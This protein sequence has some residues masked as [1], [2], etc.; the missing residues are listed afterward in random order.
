[1]KSKVFRIFIFPM[2]WNMKTE[3]K[4]KAQGKREICIKGPLKIR[5]QASDVPGGAGVFGDDSIGSGDDGAVDGSEQEQ[6]DI[7]STIVT[8]K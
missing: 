7:P 2:N 5:K 4:L 3:M 1:M 8:V 6:I